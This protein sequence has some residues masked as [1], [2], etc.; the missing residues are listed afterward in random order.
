M[1]KFMSLLTSLVLVGG[2]MGVFTGTALADTPDRFH[3]DCGYY[4]TGNP[5]MYFQKHYNDLGT[6][7]EGVRGTIHVGD[8]VKGWTCVP[9]DGSGNAYIWATSLQDDGDGLIQWG[10]CRIGSS[11]TWKMCHTLWDN[12]GGA[13]IVY[14]PEEAQL[15]ITAGHDYYFQ[16][17]GCTT[18]FGVWKW[19]LYVDDLDALTGDPTLKIDRTWDHNDGYV[20]WWGV[21]L[22]DAGGAMGYRYGVDTKTYVYNMMYKRHDNNTWVYRQQSSCNVLRNEG[23]RSIFFK[24]TTDDTKYTNDTLRVYTLPQ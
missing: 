20:A 14:A 4:Y 15:P 16:I 2:L 1:R 21:E 8:S 11:G 3:K 5:T 6:N 17:T 13:G 9:G 23:L 18:S 7:M 10:L 22:Q 12:T 24:C 19:C